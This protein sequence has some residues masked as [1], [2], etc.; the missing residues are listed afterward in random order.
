MAP[1][2][3]RVFRLAT[4]LVVSSLL[5]LPSGSLEAD[6]GGSAQASSAAPQVPPVAFHGPS[7]RY[8]ERGVF[9]RTALDVVAIPAGAA[10]WERGEWLTFGGVVAAT[11]A[12]MVPT[13]PSP[14][15]RLD[16]WIEREFDPWMP[17]LWKM[18]YQAFLWGGLALGG[19][20]SWGYAALTGNR[21][22]A[23]AMSLTGEAVAVSQVY[24][25]SLKLLTGREG[26]RMARGRGIFHGPAESLRLFPAGFPSGHFATLYAVFGTAQAYWEFPTVWDVTGH[27]LMGALASTHVLNHRH[28]L[29]E[30]IAGSAMGYAVGRWVVR[31]RSTRFEYR[32]GR[33]LRVTLL[34]T[35]R[36][37]SVAFD[38]S[39]MI[40]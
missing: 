1:V 3:R 14:D 21:R 25:L 4:V 22:L 38:L 39:G 30:I 34:P 9:E 17:D 8:D 13:D 27:V 36:G 32:D 20:G 7:Y 10:V 40:R 35:P 2:R 5:T 24:H 31:H 28:F 11:G 37:V 15:V 29:S 16:N 6:P 12:L 18:E 33:S 23:E 19:F 26:P